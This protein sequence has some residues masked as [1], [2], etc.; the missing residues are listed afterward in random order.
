MARVLMYIKSQM[1]PFNDLVTFV[2]EFPAKICKWLRQIKR[3]QC[4]K[5][6]V[7]V[8]HL[9]RQHRYRAHNYHALSGVERRAKLPEYAEWQGP[10]F[11]KVPLM[12]FTVA[13]PK[14]NHGSQ[15]HGSAQLM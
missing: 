7:F 10:G 4:R 5:E 6:A 11:A 12:N 13:V 9:E 15:R 14:S 8:R 2:K 1:S 3:R